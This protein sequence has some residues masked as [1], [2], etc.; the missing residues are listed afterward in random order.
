MDNTKAAKRIQ[1]K[2]GEVI[3]INI[4]ALVFFTAGLS[5]VAKEQTGL[6]VQIKNSFESGIDN[7][8]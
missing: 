5:K 7:H 8:S 2:R 6:F 1:E 4:L 3:T